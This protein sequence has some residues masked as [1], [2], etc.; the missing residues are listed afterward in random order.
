MLYSCTLG[1]LG[2]TRLPWLPPLSSADHCLQS[3]CVASVCECNIFVCA[4]VNG[5]LCH[6]VY[7]LL[8]RCQTA[9]APNVNVTLLW[10]T[11]ASEPSER[12][13]RQRDR[14]KRGNL[15]LLTLFN[16]R[17]ISSGELT[18]HEILQQTFLAATALSPS[19]SLFFV[20]TLICGLLAAYFTVNLFCDLIKIL[21][22]L[23]L[24][25]FRFHFRSPFSVRRSRCACISCL[26]VA[27][28]SVSLI[29]SV[30]WTSEHPKTSKKSY[31][32]HAQVFK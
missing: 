6:V 10:L 16:M 5:C 3:H 15:L 7:A 22:Q 8:L 18:T 28:G 13:S 25:R 1:A 20:L 11:F 17:L 4:C 32:R 14:R 26:H 12:T 30:A 27:S 23:R 31:H 29:R 21:A 24:I 19:R 2:G 9:V